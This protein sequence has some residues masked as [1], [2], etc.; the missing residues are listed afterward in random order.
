[1]EQH[2]RKEDA[3]KNKEEILQLLEAAWELSQVALMHC[4]GHQ[5]GKEY[6]HRRNGLA[7]QAARRAT[8]ELSSPE[9]PKQTAKLLLAPQLSSTPNYINK[10][11]Q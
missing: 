10:E 5:S 6:A 3:D 9:L 2:T 4:R 1:M 11:E 8:E 7:D